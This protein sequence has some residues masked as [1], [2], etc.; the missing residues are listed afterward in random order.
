[1]Q[2]SCKR[3][4]V[5]SR[6]QVR[7]IFLAVIL[8]AGIAGSARAQV[9]A[10]ISGRVED[11]SEA[12]IPGA[13]VTVTSLETG[14]ERTATTGPAGTYRVLSLPV[15]RYE[16]KAEAAGFQAVLQTGVS[17]TAGEEAAVNLKLAVGAVQGQ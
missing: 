11:S 16:V 9:T 1:M 10:S 7:G 8:A 13:T 5:V 2:N 14:A 6:Q 4:L 12:A 17:L 15:G 3:R